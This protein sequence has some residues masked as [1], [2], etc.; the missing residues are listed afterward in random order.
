M[1]RFIPGYYSLILKNTSLKHLALYHRNLTEPCNTTY[2]ARTRGFQKAQMKANFAEMV[3][4]TRRV[5]EV[6]GFY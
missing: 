6:G 5:N 1:T 2:S 3:L 4:S